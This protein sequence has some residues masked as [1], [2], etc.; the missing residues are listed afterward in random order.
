MDNEAKERFVP[1]TERFYDTASHRS[2]QASQH[3]PVYQKETTLPKRRCPR[4]GK[5]K[6]VIEAINRGKSSDAQTT[7]PR[8]CVKTMLADAESPKRLQVQ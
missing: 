8:L 1:T 7:K 3:Q 4:R 6:R 2:Q 5:P